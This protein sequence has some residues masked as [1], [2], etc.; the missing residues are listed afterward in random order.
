MGT[1]YIYFA[2]MTELILA[3][4]EPVMA[5]AEAAYIRHLEQIWPDEALYENCLRFLENFHGF[6]LRHARILHMRNSVSDQQDKRMM[7]H[8]VTAATRIISLFVAQMRHDVT[9]IRSEA[10]GMATVLYTGIERIIV[11]STDRVMPTVVPGK[12]SPHVENYLKSEAKLL[13]FGISEYRKT[14]AG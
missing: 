4:L 7:A 13:A 11:V 12:F 2:D 5:E 6:W 8:R 3:V 1:L 10:A 9:V 14:A